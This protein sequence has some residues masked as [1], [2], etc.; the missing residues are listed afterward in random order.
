M[1]D[2]TDYLKP[3]HTPCLEHLQHIISWEIT[4]YLKIR[5]SKNQDYIF[6]KQYKKKNS[7]K[8]I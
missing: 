7:N 1:N 4:M 5:L 8:I 2:R 6:I 3:K